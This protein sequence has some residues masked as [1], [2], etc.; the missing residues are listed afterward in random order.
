[1]IRQLCFQLEKSGQIYF[2]PYT[3]IVRLS[4]KKGLLRR[5]DT[6]IQILVECS[7][8]DALDQI[9]ESLSEGIEEVALAELFGSEQIVEIC[10]AK[11][12]IE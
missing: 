3:D 10:R 7:A 5:R 12:V 11:G 9:I 4:E 6:G 1:M 8:A 2:S